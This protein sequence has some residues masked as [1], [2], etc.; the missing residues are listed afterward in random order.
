[1]R[2]YGTYYFLRATRF[3]IE[4]L[5]G[6]LPFLN[7]VYFFRRGKNYLSFSGKKRVY[8]RK[9]NPYYHFLLLLQ[10]LVLL[11][12]RPYSRGENKAAIEVAKREGRTLNGGKYEIYGLD[13]ETL[14]ERIDAMDGWWKDS[15]WTRLL[16]RELPDL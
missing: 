2:G 7:H 13:E 1:M 3:C 6:S 8:F 14:W 5:L 15:T 10:N 4:L 16:Q 9:K 11:T 12:I